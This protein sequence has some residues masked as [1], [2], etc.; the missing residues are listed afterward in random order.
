M[1][2]NQD[3]GVAAM[4]LEFIAESLKC[5]AVHVILVSCT[6]I[7]VSAC[8]TH[9]VVLLRVFRENQLI[10]ENEFNF[11]E[12]QEP[13]DYVEEICESMQVANVHNLEFLD[14]YCHACSSL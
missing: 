10:D 13:D 7:R 4:G 5:L 11:Q 3:V 8:C 14:R 12:D 1:E 2:F 9:C 6:C